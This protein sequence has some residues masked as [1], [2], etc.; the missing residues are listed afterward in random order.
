ML[1]QRKPHSLLLFLLIFTVGFSTSGVNAKVIDRILAVVGNQPILQSEMESRLTLIQKNPSYSNILGLNP[2][3]A[4]AQSVL[5]MMI[6]E[7]VVNSVSKELEISVS[8]VDVNKQIDSIAH[9]NRIDR[10]QLVQSLKNE[11]IPFEAYA[12]NI[13]LQ[14]QKRGIIERELRGASNIDE[15]ALRKEYQERASREYQIILLDVPKKDQVKTQKAFA[16][17]QWDE[18]ALKYPTQDLGWVAANN[19]KLNVADALKRAKI[20]SM[21]GPIEIGG[22]K[23]LIFVRAE[24]IGSEEEYQSIKGQLAAVTQSKN[25]ESR[26]DAWIENK[27]KEM[28][29]VVN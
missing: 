20:N 19:I 2:K 16:P 3:N 15:T 23:Q 25:I 11:G 5:N 18:L 26:F 29:I 27:K 1:K 17:S 28:H 4:S 7:E 22:K 21:I 24:R 10:D 13:R 8:D 14:L 6:E 9:Q 12:R